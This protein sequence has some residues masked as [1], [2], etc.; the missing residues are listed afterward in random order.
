MSCAQWMLAPG[1]DPGK[2]AGYLN[3]AAGADAVR[4]MEADWKVQRAEGAEVILLDREGLAQRF[5]SPKGNCT[6]GESTSL[7]GTSRMLVAYSAS[8]S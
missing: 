3:L 2:R 4:V 1:G 7:W 8:R 5:P 6:I